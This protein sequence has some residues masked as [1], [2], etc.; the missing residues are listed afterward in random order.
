MTSSVGMS[1]TPGNILLN[2]RDLKR[3]HTI[4]AFL[5]IWLDVNIDSSNSDHSF[6]RSIADLSDAVSSIYTFMDIDEC[7]DFLTDVKYEGYS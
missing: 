2:D 7:M 5:L 3:R 4:Q 6:S 1:E